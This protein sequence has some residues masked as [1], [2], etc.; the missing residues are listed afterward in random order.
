MWNNCENLKFKF[1]KDVN[2]CKMRISEK[3]SPNLLFSK[4]LLFNNMIKFAGSYLQ[5]KWHQEN[6]TKNS[7]N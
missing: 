3:V 6:L 2:K 4:Y 1:A 5:R 7:K